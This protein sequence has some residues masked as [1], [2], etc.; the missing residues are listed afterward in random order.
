MNVGDTVRCIAPFT[1]AAVEKHQRGEGWAHIIPERSVTVEVGDVGTVRFTATNNHV[2]AAVYFYRLGETTVAL[3]S[4]G[5]GGD[6]EIEL[7]AP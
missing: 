3:F 1:Y 4:S 6:A 2:A 5:R 7:V